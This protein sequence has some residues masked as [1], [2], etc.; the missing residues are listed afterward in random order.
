MTIIVRVTQKGQVVNFRSQ[1]GE[2]VQKVECR[3]AQG[4]NEF[5]ASAFD[6]E[7][8]KIAGMQISETTLYVADL[9]FGV[10]KSSQ[11][12]GKVFQNVRILKLSE[13]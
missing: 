10:S 12:G 3:L 4:N 8:L 11:D 13:I 6:K 2:E 5:V 7:A 1:S 9:Q